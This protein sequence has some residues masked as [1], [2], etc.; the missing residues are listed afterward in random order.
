GTTVAFDGFQT[1]VVNFGTLYKMRFRLEGA[2]PGVSRCEISVG[3]NSTSAKW[4][5]RP[6]PLRD[7]DL[8]QFVAGMVPDTYDQRLYVDVP[9]TVPI[10]V[11]AGGVVT[12]FDGWWFGRHLGYGNHQP[13]DADARVRITL[14]G[15]GLNWS[16]EFRVGDIVQD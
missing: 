1:R 9:Y 8:S 7:D 4:D 3:G 14:R 11:S 12:V 5:E 15:S 6:N 13:L 10:L 2:D 16:H